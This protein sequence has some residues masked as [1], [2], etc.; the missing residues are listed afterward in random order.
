MRLN[1]LAGLLLLLISIT[2]VQAQT[3]TVT[4][5]SGATLLISG[6]EL[7]LDCND[8]EVIL[9]SGGT[10]RITGGSISDINLKRE[11]GSIYQK[12]GGVVKECD[13]FYII[14]TPKG[15]AIINL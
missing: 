1:K 12:L 11:S 13:S 14:K 9:K 7:S 3:S 5:N 10:L 8:I 15:A 6:G 4:I 2:V